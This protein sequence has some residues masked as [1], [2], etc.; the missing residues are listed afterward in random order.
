MESP[1]AEV[2][3]RWPLLL[4]T[5]GST[6]STLQSVPQRPRLGWEAQS[7]FSLHID[8]IQIEQ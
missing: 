3:H 5:A 8:C 6:G 4:L 1:L 2:Y 7:D